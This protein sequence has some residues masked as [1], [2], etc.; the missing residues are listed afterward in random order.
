MRRTT[1]ADIGT[2]GCERREFTVHRT[3]LERPSSLT[4]YFNCPWC[5]LEV[6]AYVWSISGGGK[7]CHCG[8]IFGA[9]AGYKLREGVA[10]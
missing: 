6:K 5:G 7:R 10:S 3:G 9:S 2:P 4:W 8:A 1:F